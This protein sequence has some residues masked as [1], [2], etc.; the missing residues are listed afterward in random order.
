MLSLFLLPVRFSFLSLIGSVL[1][2]KDIYRIGRSC[3]PRYNIGNPPAAA[4][5]LHFFKM[6]ASS[7]SA[8]TPPQY[9]REWWLSQIR[10]ILRD[11]KLIIQSRR[12]TMSFE[13]ESKSWFHFLLCQHNAS[14]AIMQVVN[15]SSVAIHLKSNTYNSYHIIYIIYI[16]KQYILGRSEKY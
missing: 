16:T 2:R 11:S 13:I 7:S 3:F 14:V 12:R 8:S 5:L 1:P 10:Q 15:M 4:S 9:C 6:R